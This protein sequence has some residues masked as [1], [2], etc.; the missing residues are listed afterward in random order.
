MLIRCKECSQVVEVAT[1]MEHL[2]VECEHHEKY[3]QCSRCSESVKIEKY[4]SHASRC[5]G[6]KNMKMQSSHM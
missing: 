1:L 2:L 5:K 6:K 4:E 3:T